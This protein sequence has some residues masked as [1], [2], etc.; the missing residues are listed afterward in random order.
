MYRLRLWCYYDRDRSSQDLQLGVQLVSSVLVHH[1]K[2]DD[3]IQATHCHAS[4]GYGVF[5]G[6]HLFNFY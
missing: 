1:E 6:A 5:D 2:F 3:D 4:F